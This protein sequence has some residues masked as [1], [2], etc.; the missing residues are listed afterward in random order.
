MHLYTIPGLYC[1]FS[2][3]IHPAVNEI[4]AHTQQWLL[5][6]KLINSYD[7]LNL[8]KQQRFASMIARSYPYG[9]YV[10]LC[11]WCD[12]NT[13]LF[14][15]DDQLDEQDI[16]K[17]KE[18][19]LRFESD[20]LEVLQSNRSCSLEKDGPVLTA[21]SDFWRRMLLRS[22]Q[23]W[24]DKFIQGIKDMF[25]GGMWQFKHIMDN[26]TPDL[27]EYIGIRQYLGAANLATDSLEV[28]GKISLGEE[29]YKTP[30]VTKLTEICRN[31]ICFANDLFS[32]SKEV[33]QSNGAEFN[34]VTILRRKHNL[35]MERAISEAARVHDATVHEFIDL[36]GKAYIYDKETNFM[37]H[38]YVHALEYLM[39][40]NI[41]WST[42]ETTRY[43]H[44]YL[45]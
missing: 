29:I 45:N 40:G 21:L 25:A 11:T 6:F 26:R 4:E 37:L 38:K 1:P 3:A 15:V 36:S 16:I 44:I 31:A 28:T 35:T 41:D 39:K 10:D 34:L 24:Q 18:A 13:L 32:L 2:P 22:G 30:L 5:D 27:D 42:R 23:V 8:Y 33:A 9:D 17:D 43:P 14:I 12:L 7:M 20:F 19:F